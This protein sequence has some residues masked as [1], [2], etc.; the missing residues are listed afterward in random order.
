MKNQSKPSK[1]LK[2]LF[3]ELVQIMTAFCGRRDW[4]ILTYK[5]LAPFNQFKLTDLMLNK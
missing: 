1:E 2:S 3:Q 4:A 5:N